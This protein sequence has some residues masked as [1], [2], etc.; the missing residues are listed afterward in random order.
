MARYVNVY[1]EGRAYGGPEEGGWWYG[2]GEPVES[3]QV[4]SDEEEVITKEKLK[5]KYSNDEGYRPNSVVYDEE[6][7]IRVEDHFAKPFPENR[8]S[9]E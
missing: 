6:Y 1:L 2:C 4:F 5:E 3:I 8:P 7:G 9:Y